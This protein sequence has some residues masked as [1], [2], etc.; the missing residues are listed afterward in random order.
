M[1]KM[2]KDFLTVHALLTE[3]RGN[4]VLMFLTSI[5]CHRSLIRRPQR[6]V[7]Q[8]NDTNHMPWSEL[9]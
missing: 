7:I 5:F 3:I 6:I 1:F 2:H 4:K 9:C 8:R